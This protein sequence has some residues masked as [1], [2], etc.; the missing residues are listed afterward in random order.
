[1]AFKKKN[2]AYLLGALVISS[3]ASGTS[4][5]GFYAG[6]DIGMDFASMKLSSE[7]KTLEGKKSGPMFA[8]DGGYI[9][10]ISRFFVGIEGNFGIGTARPSCVFSDQISVS[11]KRRYSFGFTSKVGYSLFGGVSSVLNAGVLRSNYSLNVNNNDG[12]LRR[13][14]SSKTSLLLGGELRYD[15]GPVFLRAGWDVLFPRKVASSSDMVG[16]DNGTLK[17]RSYVLRIGAG[18]KFG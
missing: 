16:I 6:A 2:I 17:K 8:V 11:L 9:F 7:N 12:S 10:G 3:S 5:T 15:I 13:S 1:M 4:L 18:Y 14:S